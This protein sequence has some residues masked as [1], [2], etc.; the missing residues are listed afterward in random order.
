MPT[1]AVSKKDLVR[2][3][4]ANLAM[5]VAPVRSL[6]IKKGRTCDV[7]QIREKF[8]IQLDEFLEIAGVAALSGK[9]I[10]EV[11]PGDVIAMGLLFIGAGARSYSA[12]DRFLG[13]VSG[14]RARDI[15]SQVYQAAPDFVKK[16]LEDRGLALADFPWINPDDPGAPL[17]AFPISI[18]HGCETIPKSDIIFSYNVV[19]HLFDIDTAFSN[20]KRSLRPGGMM[21]HR[22]DFG[23]HG[24]WLKY[25]NPLTFLTVSQRMW[26]AMGSHRGLP[27]RKRHAE[28]I[29]SL[30]RCGFACESTAVQHFELSHVRALRSQLPLSQQALPDSDLSIRA[31]WI[32]AHSSKAN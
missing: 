20:M 30:E 1:P 3:I 12:I 15:Y 28:I 8:C 10:M 22:V 6:R 26:N 31:A 16:G 23:P 21:V 11:G 29:A 7:S 5:Q 4:A 32:V 17:Q 13:D 24:C 14:H 25:E 27:N 19:E 2:E 9:A 18:E